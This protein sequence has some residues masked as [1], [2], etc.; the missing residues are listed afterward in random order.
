MVYT[1][2]AIT[3]VWLAMLVLFAV[4][5]SGSVTGPWVLL[6]AAAA[7]VAPMSLTLWP[8]AR[9]GWMRRMRSTRA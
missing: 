9:G 8:K 7:F 5:A 3:T 2:K 6:I 4:S 1:Y